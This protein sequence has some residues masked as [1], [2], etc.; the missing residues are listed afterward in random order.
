MRSRPAP[1]RASDP[2]YGPISYLAWRY[3]NCVPRWQSLHRTRR[4]SDTHASACP[5]GAN[6]IV[7]VI[8]GTL[9]VLVYPADDLPHLR[10]TYGNAP[11]PRNCPQNGN[12]D[13]GGVDFVGD[14]TREQHAGADAQLSNS[15]GQSLGSEG[16]DAGSDPGKSWEETTDGVGRDVEE[17]ASE[18]AMGR[19]SLESWPHEPK[20]CASVWPS[21]EVGGDDNST[22]AV[23]PRLVASNVCCCFAS[24]SRLSFYGGMYYSQR[25]FG[26]KY[27]HSNTPRVDVSYPRQKK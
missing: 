3:T 4:G 18:K 12:D 11:C 5:S 1:T 6:A 13:Q 14:F 2:S 26:S 22:S 24:R 9:E 20:F 15:D 16:N 19:R 8:S 27:E 7:V 10:P 23:P 17:P 25:H 21:D